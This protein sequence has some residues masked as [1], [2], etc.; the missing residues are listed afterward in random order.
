MTVAVS[1]KDNTLTVQPPGQPALTLVPTAQDMFS[2]AEGPG[3]SV[4]FVG[5][6]G[7]VERLVLTSPQG[8]QNFPRLAESAAPASPAAGT[9]PL[10]AGCR[11]S[12]QACHACAGAADSRD[13]TDGGR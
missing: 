6:G 7:M 3:L 13:Q 4:A 11:G 10:A 5:R 9:A 2:I 8:T 12:C 1:L